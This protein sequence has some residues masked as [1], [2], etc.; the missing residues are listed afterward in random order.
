MEVYVAGVG[1]TPF[2]GDDDVTVRSLAEQAVAEALSD[3]G[4]TA[5]DVDAVFFA[6]AADGLI[7]GQEMIRG[8]AALRFTGLMGKPVV[9]VENACASASTAFGL[10]CTAIRAGEADIVVV[11]GSEKL[12]HPDRQRSLGAIATAVDL[13]DVARLDERLAQAGLPTSPKGSPSARFMA[14]YAR[15]ARDYMRRTGATA[16]DFAAAAVKGRRHGALNP[17]AHYRS[18]VTL[19]EVMGSREIVSPLTLRMC[20]PVSNGAAA[21]VLCSATARDRLTATVRV[22]ATALTSGTDGDDT[23]AVERAARLAYDRAGITPMDLDVIEI[24]DAASPAELITVEELG[25]CAPGDGARLL[26]SGE[27]SL[28]GSR[29]VN[30]GGGLIARGHPIGATGC[31]QIIELTEQL[32]GRCGPRQVHGARVG[33]AENGGGYLLSDSASATVTILV[34]DE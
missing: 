1:M 2:R 34:K 27:T 25:L 17:R 10:G 6:N 12:T 18:E 23:G 13:G 29:V 31:A 28:G 24:H 8:Q 3:A 33:L 7:S 5:P 22:A 21:I 15:M 19:D 16:S 26:H 14:I 30:P 9:N 32:L 4:V 20:C 11:V